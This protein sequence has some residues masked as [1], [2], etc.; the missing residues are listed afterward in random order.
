MLFQGN[1]NVRGNLIMHS[2]G[3]YSSKNKHNVS[4]FQCPFLIWL[5]WDYH[6]FRTHTF[7]TIWSYQIITYILLSHHHLNNTENSQSNWS[8]FPH[9][10]VQP[11]G[12]GDLRP[13][14]PW[15]GCRGLSGTYLR[16]WAHPYQ[17]VR[18]NIVCLLNQASIWILVVY[19]LM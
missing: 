6:L 1:L 9:D 17:G 4:Y 7:D 11:G 13:H 5:S 8:H 14:L 15:W 19:S 2:W 10:F 12:W 18:G 3:G 16:W